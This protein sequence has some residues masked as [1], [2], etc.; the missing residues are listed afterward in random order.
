MDYKSK[1]IDIFNNDNNKQ[2]FNE[3]NIF[4]KLLKEY[5][6]ICM[7]SDNTHYEK[8][9]KDLYYELDTIIKRYNNRKKIKEHYKLEL[10]ELID[11]INRYKEIYNYAGN[12]Y[13]GNSHNYSRNKLNKI[14][15]DNINSYFGDKYIGHT[16][17]EK[18]DFYKDMTI[19][20][21]TKYKTSS[22]IRKNTETLIKLNKEFL[23]IIEVCNI[24]LELYR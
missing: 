3:L 11:F 16:I 8:Q 5:T 19:T 24:D 1:I 20:T 14:I 22:K 4:N 15:N 18:F 6:K 21:S 12:C 17:K 2:I 10:T 13:M 9:L 23:K 7:D